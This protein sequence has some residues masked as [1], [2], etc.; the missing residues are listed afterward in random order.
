MYT[1]SFPVSKAHMEVRGA[2]THTWKGHV[3]RSLDFIRDSNWLGIV[4]RQSM[5][6]EQ[7]R[8]LYGGDAGPFVG[9]L[10]V[11]PTNWLYI[12]FQLPF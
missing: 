8:H 5:V 1:H 12:R 10:C 4:M 6:R 7:L 2:L 11:E 3:R 9:K